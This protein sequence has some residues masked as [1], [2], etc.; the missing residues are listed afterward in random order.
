MKSYLNDSTANKVALSTVVSGLC[1][2]EIS[3]V[4]GQIC[5]GSEKSLIP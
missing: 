3:S 1:L 4:I 2:F 5:Q